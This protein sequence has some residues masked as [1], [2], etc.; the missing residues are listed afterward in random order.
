MSECVDGCGREALYCSECMTESVKAWRDDAR[1]AQKERDDLKAKLAEA[2]KKLASLG[3]FP[4]DDPNIRPRYAHLS[5][6][7]RRAQEAK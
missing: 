4:W 1:A 3:W 7:A 2:E 5:K 6:K